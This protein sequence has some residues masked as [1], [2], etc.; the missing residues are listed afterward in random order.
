MQEVALDASDAGVIDGRISCRLP[1]AGQL[2]QIG[3][4]G[5]GCRG[6]SRSGEFWG[7]SCL[8]PHWLAKLPVVA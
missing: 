2:D 4:G 8:P 7:E 6:L 3:P 1:R 5:Q